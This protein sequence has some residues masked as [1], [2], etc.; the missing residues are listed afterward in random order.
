[1]PIAVKKTRKN[2]YQTFLFLSS[3]TGLL[4]FVPNILSGIVDYGDVI[5]DKAYNNFFQQRL[6]SLQYKVSL[7]ITG[8][9]KDSSTKR[10]YQEL[11]LESLQNRRRFRKL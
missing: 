8:A 1:M 5:F 11:V 3:F 10:F 2:K 6:E 9:I 4:Y 7:A